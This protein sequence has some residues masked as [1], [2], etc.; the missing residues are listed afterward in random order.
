M[1]AVKKKLILRHLVVWIRFSMKIHGNSRLKTKTLDFKTKKSRVF[2]QI[3]KIAAISFYFDA[4]II[5]EEHI[6]NML[7][8]LIFS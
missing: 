8:L 4:I 6:F 7:Q 2:P 1:Y 3:L 5:L